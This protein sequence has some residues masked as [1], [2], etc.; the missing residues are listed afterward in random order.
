MR[1]KTWINKFN[2]ML[3]V[4]PLG[5]TC[6]MVQYQ[7]TEKGEFCPALN[8]LLLDIVWF[9]IL[10]WW[11]KV[12]GHWVNWIYDQILLTN[13][14]TCWVLNDFHGRLCFRSE[15]CCAEELFMINKFKFTKYFCLLPEPF[16]LKPFQQA[17][18]HYQFTL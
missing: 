2:T 18:G 12:N 1:Q 7:N 10:D 8:I 3:F 15:T 5:Y 17:L 11:T 4:G 16:L 9:S 14:F 13:I 6:S